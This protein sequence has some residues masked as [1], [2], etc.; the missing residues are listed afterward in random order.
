SEYE[1]NIDENIEN[2][3][4]IGINKH[5]QDAK[6]DLISFVQQTLNQYLWS[7]Q[8]RKDIEI[9]KQKQKTSA[10]KLKETSKCVEQAKR[11]AATVEKKKALRAKL[12]DLYKYNLGFEI[13]PLK[14]GF[15]EEHSEIMFS[16]HHINKSKP[17][18][19]YNFI[20]VLNGQKYDV[21]LCT[22]QIKGIDELLVELNETNDLS[23]FVIQVRRNFCATATT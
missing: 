16:F 4:L 13:K 17:E 12:Y 15:N 3:L 7:Q 19:E 11:A 18:E 14:G 2:E 10:L 22:P 5:V 1:T 6:C 23:A 21:K 9:L 20:L 8:F